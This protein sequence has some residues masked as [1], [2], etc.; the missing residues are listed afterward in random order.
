MWWWPRGPNDPVEASV[1]QL[2]VRNGRDR[3]NNYHRAWLAYEAEVP[4]ALKPT[5]SDPDA[6]DNVVIN[7]PALIVDTT[8]SYLFGDEMDKPHF[9][10]EDDGEE[11]ADES[12][13][14]KWLS[15]AWRRNQKETLLLKWGTYGAVCGHSFLR[16]VPATH[17]TA[18]RTRPY[19]RILALDPASVDVE[20][21]GEDIEQAV[22]YKLEWTAGS[23]NQTVHF[24]Q[25]HILS[26][27]GLSWTI[28]D[29]TKRAGEARFT[30][31]AR[32]VW[33]YPWSQIHDCQHFPNPGIYYGLSELEPDVLKLALSI[34]FGYSNLSRVDRIYA[35]PRSYV[36]GH[37]SK[38]P[39]R[40]DPDFMLGLNKDAKV[41][42][43]EMQSEYAGS[44]ALTAA[45][46]AELCRRTRLPPT[47]FGGDSEASNLSAVALAVRFR[48]LKQKV[49]T[50]RLT[51]GGLL[52]QLNAHM[53]ELG[54]KGK[55]HIV[56]NTWGELIPASTLEER[57][58]IQIELQ[59]GIVSRETAATRLGYS[60]ATEKA[61]LEAEKDIPISGVPEEVPGV[62][63]R[64]DVSAE[65]KQ[66]SSTGA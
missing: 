39:I 57:Q 2:L 47:V 11:G 61:R 33:N 19:P 32:E 1:N 51:Y 27:N 26:D 5:P 58:G 41:G 38:E 17:P 20:W 54:G 28:V 9:E 34:N 13:M 25:R 52:S 8:V 50:L 6:R 14:E 31:A 64:P 43:L 24:R 56:T 15:E 21:N 37:T 36:T 62:M 49:K 48:P 59:T 63:G 40:I 12:P 65:R 66:R 55:D 60:W 30:E 16:L 29:E 42:I 10:V 23:G 45:K 53:L 46:M 7:T 35:H 22:E 4:L 3:L 44:L 18:G